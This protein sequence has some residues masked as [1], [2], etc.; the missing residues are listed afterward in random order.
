MAIAKALF[1]GILTDVF[2]VGNKIDLFSVMPTEGNESGYTKI[3]GTGYESY[4][5]QSGDF[6]VSGGVATSNR[7]MMLYLCDDQS[8]HG[9]A[10]GF[11]VFSGNSLLYYGE[12]QKPMTISYNS[13]PTIK[14][15]DLRKN[16]G[17]RVAVTST[18]VAG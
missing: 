4:E 12:F 2:K 10:T 15:Y 8:G 17:V 16:E 3:S 1:N 6:N 18:E 9:V 5:I 11:G 7:N 14:K 13:V